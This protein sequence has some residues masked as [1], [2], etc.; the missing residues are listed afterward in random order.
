MLAS[1]TE[2]KEPHFEEHNRQNVDGDEATSCNEVEVREL[3]PA[4]SNS[5][6]DGEPCK[7]HRAMIINEWMRWAGS[8]DQ[9]RCTALA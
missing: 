2:S 5:A 6:A 1:G 3:H 9:Q 4:H 7:H 8:R